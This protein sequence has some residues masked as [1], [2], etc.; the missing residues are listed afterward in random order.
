MEKI[1]EDVKKSAE[2]IVEVAKDAR[3]KVNKQMEK[4]AEEI[5]EVAK[6]TRKKVNKQIEKIVDCAEES[7][8]EMAEEW[9]ESF[10]D[11]GL[12]AKKTEKKA[13][14]AAKEM[15]QAWSD[16]G[17]TVETIIDDINKKDITIK[18]NFDKNEAEEEAN[19]LMGNV[20]DVFKEKASEKIPV[21]GS[22]SQYTEGL[23][24]LKANAIGASIGIATEAIAI[25]DGM[26]TAMNSFLASTGKSIGETERYQTILENIYAKGYGDN[27]GEIANSM[28]EVARAVGDIDDKTFQNITES[29]YALQEV[30]GLDVSE[31]IGIAKKL[32]EDYG[33]SGEDAMALITVGAQNG[34][35]SSDEF[36]EKIS[37]YSD[38]LD[39]TKVSAEDLFKVFGEDAESAGE[40]LN[41]LKDNHGGTLSSMFEQLKNNIDLL[42]EPIGDLLIPILQLLIDTILPIISELLK[43]IIEL[44]AALLEPIVNLIT[45]AIKPLIDIFQMLM[46]EAINPLIQLIE[47]FLLPLFAD[48]LQ[49]MASDVERVFGNVKKHFSLVIDFIKNVFAGNWKAALEN[50]KDILKNA[51]EACIN[52]IKMPLNFMIDNVNKFIVGLNRIKIP[53]WVPGIGG[54]GFE[55]SKLPRLKVG[56][57]YVPSDYFPAFLDEGEA[58]LT[59]E[60]NVLFRS[61]GGLEGMIQ[62]SN[63]QY[64]DI[65][66][67]QTESTPIIIH[68]HVNLDGKEVGNSV[69][70]YVDSN[71]SENES[72]RWRGN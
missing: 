46:S 36:L 17:K 14:S 59:K 54:K 34:L 26:D 8:K 50:I 72:L 29:A 66:R 7:A 5:V 4:S 56:I 51:F 63:G 9:E 68:S 33:L 15:E 41:E 16:S 12:S 44:C 2:E 64:P 70:K 20:K 21:I 27:F 43:P 22:I 19:T 24:G 25:A 52:Y 58:V 30:I 3:K 23:S 49:G 39:D 11:I 10:E 6:D 28:A 65:F 18:V 69:T 37:Q 38:E 35:K 13:K 62:L 71:F 32:M 61:L 47:E 60:E 45:T 40:K 31:S 67:L 55:I 53:D 48:R 42:L 1:S 57:D